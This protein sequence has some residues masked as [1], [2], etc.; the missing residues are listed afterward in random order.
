[1]DPGRAG[2]KGDCGAVLS[3]R[4]GGE[5]GRQCEADGRAGAAVRED[6]ADGAGVFGG[7]EGGDGGGD[8]GIPFDA[9]ALG[10]RGPGGVTGGWGG[11]D[12]EGVGGGGGTVADYGVCG[13]KP[14][15]GG[16]TGDVG[17]YGEGVTG[18]GYGRFGHVFSV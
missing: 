4:G 17:G 1:M 3:V 15:R 7:L 8:P 18:A 9:G 10:A 12:R 14:R 11:E 16:G 2:S 6:G 13:E 5:T